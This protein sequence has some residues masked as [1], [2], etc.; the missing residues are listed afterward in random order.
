MHIKENDE[1]AQDTEQ[2][3]RKIRKKKTEN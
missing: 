1:Q 2:M 3:G